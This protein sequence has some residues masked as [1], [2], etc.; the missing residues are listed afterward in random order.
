MTTLLILYFASG[1]LLNVVC[2]PLLAQKIPP[3]PLYG[4]R[5]QATLGNRAVWYAANRFAARRFMLAGMSI[6]AASVVLYFVPDLPLEG[7]ALILLALSLSAIG[8]ALLQSL[9]YVRRLTRGQA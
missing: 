2:L 6:S 4:F 9:R 5:I 1:L 8:A 7:Y 3:N